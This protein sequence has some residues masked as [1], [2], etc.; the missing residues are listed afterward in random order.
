MNKEN[1][2]DVSHFKG[3]MNKTKR[4]TKHNIFTNIPKRMA[5]ENV[6]LLL[7]RRGISIKRIIS[8]GQVTDWLKQDTDEWVILLAGKARILFEGR[9]REVELRDGDYLFIPAGCRHRVTWTDPKRDSVW[10]AV[11]IAA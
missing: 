7:R 2:G 6:D 8:H 10:V 3:L 11:N 5:K 4:I 1:K 9:K